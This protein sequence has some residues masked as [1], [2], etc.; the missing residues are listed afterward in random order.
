M[1][2]AQMKLL[3]S[4]EMVWSRERAELKTGGETQSGSLLAPRALG[5]VNLTPIRPTRP[6]ARAPMGAADAAPVWQCP[7][8]MAGRDSQTHAGAGWAWMHLTRQSLL[9]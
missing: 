7:A 4:S 1:L 5:E 9:W 8:C 3:A 6:R 2:S